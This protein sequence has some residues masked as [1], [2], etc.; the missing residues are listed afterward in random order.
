[1]NLEMKASMLPRHC[2]GG[3]ESLGGIESLKL[4]M[5]GFYE[6]NQ[7]GFPVLSETEMTLSI[8]Y[9]TSKKGK[10]KV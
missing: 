10:Q 7:G 9:T 8:I 5:E 3:L 1:M 2:D 6:D 4:I